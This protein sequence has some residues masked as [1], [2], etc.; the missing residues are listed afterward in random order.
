MMLL[1]RLLRAL[2]SPISRLNRW[3]DAGVDR[4]RRERLR[5]R[6]PDGCWVRAIDA[7]PCG[8]EHAGKVGIVGDMTTDYDEFWVNFDFGKGN[9]N[10]TAILCPKGMERVDLCPRGKTRA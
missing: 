2:T 7:C 6:F 8:R 3:A 1:Y 5:R 10:A 4:C 9:Y